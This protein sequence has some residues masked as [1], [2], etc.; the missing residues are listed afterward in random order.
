MNEQVEHSSDTDSNSRPNMNVMTGDTAS[1]SD[2][3]DQAASSA[4]DPAI[5]APT[6]KQFIQTMG[7][8]DASAVDDDPADLPLGTVEASAHTLKEAPPVLPPASLQQEPQP[9]SSDPSTLQTMPLHPVVAKELEL[10]QY[11]RSLPLPLH[12]VVPRLFLRCFARCLVYLKCDSSKVAYDSVIMFL[13]LIAV[14]FFREVQPRSRFRIPK[15]GPIIF[16]GAPHHNQ[17]LD[18][19]LLASEARLA[20]RRVSFLIAQKSAERPFIGFLSRMLQSISVTRAADRAK[21]G[22]GAIT[23]HPSGDL[24][25]LR[26][27][28]SSFTTQ[29]ERHGHVVLPRETGYAMGEV[30]EVLSDDTVRIKKPFTNEVAIHALERG[31]T[32]KCFPYVDQKQM[33]ANVYQRLSEGGCLCIFPEG[34]SHDRT[35]LLPLKAGVVIMAL[36]AMANDPNL[37]VKIVPVG[38][39]YF[40]P[41]K[42]RSRAVIE[43]G[44]PLSVPP[45]QVALFKQGG[46][47]KHQAVAFMLDLVYD[48]L[49]SVTFRAPDYETLMLIQA[50][51]RLIKL[52]GQQLTLGDK[53]EMNRK[54]IMGFL[55]F[56]DH[57]DVIALRDA[58]RTYNDH[59]MQIGIRD[60]QVERANRSVLRSLMLLLYRLGLLVLWGGCALPG[61]VLNAPITI[62][63]RIV[64]HR[65]AKEALAA[66]QVKLYGRDVLA[67]WKVLVSLGV[68]PVLYIF[69]AVLA[70]MAARRSNLRP[71][72]KRLMPLYVLFGLPIASYGVIRI[73]EVGVD[74]Y[75][76]LPPL[77]ASLLPGRRRVIERIQQERIDLA[78]QLH[79]TIDKLAPEGWQNTDFAQ[80]SLASAPPNAEELAE[81]VQSGRSLHLTSHHSLSHPF[82]L[83]DEWVFG[84]GAT[85]RRQTNSHKTGPMQ[86]EDDLGP[87]YEEAL[88]VYA[89]KADA[90]TGKRMRRRSSHEYRQLHPSRSPSPKHG[91][92]PSTRPNSGNGAIPPFHLSETHN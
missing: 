33:Y 7:P 14:I 81:L 19:V 48:G 11:L 13:R 38:L 30:V 68:T 9:P 67:T 22:R 55:K 58:V 70:S 36:G 83:I 44:R 52:P 60:H 29:L 34:G 89:L 91:L 43:F 40:H 24:T 32:Y 16:V 74:V 61:F 20:G 65:K 47:G 53:V 50:G 17:F 2:V 82:N 35:D 63:A 66:S 39:S 25:L 88:S 71:L 45:E 3:H 37:D 90:Q 5:H 69:Y 12:R 64:S 62:L 85:W 41:H 77:I 57:P 46:E 73:S 92:S 56:K 72:H 51:R 78:A 54:L 18:P 87:D 42:F 28:G 76:S 75:R 15:T 84:W 86:V 31:T 80:L 1:L 6:T 10:A 59:L 79:A 26:G 27:V 4:A 23:M 21:V 8:S 49:K